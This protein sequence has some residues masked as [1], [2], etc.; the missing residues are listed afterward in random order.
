MAVGRGAGVEQAQSG[1]GQV[2]EG[3]LAARAV[4]RVAAEHQVEMPICQQVHA[5]VH[6]G[7]GIDA[8]V[9]SLMSR[10]IRAEGD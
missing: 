5:I 9:Q 1:I 8:A 6:E 7:R 10:E 4:L 3:V 2:V